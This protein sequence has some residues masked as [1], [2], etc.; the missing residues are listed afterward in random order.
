MSKF[1]AVEYKSGKNTTTGQPNQK[2]G[3]MSI[4]TDS[5]AFTSKNDRDAW[6]A[7]GEHTSDMRGNCRSAV[8]LRQLRNLC[9]GMSIDEFAE[10]IQYLPYSTPQND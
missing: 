2:T 6:V 10:H 4:A 3:Y 9:L 7:D 5:V 1:Y 8:T